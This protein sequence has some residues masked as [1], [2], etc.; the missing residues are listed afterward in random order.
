MPYS[1]DTSFTDTL[2]NCAPMR[3][4]LIATY[5]EMAKTLEHL[6]KGT[7]IK[8]I[9]VYAS[10]EDAVIA[11]K[12]LKDSVDIILTRGGT[13]YLIKQSISIPVISIPI[14]PFDLLRSVASLP[15]QYKRIAFSNFERGIFGTD[16]IE[17]TYKK[18]IYQ[19]HFTNRQDLKEIVYKAK[20]DGC[21]LFIGGAEGALYAQNIGLMTREIFSG[22]EAVYQALA[23]AIELVKVQRAERIVSKRLASAFNAL[24]EGICVTSE[25]GKITVFN[26]AAKRIMGFPVDETYIGKSIQDIHHKSIV[27]SIESCRKP[28]VNQ[29]LYICDKAVSANY[30]PIYEDQAFIG[31]VSTFQ[32]V[33]KIQILEGQIRRQLS[34]KGL[35]ARYTFDDILTQ[36]QNMFITKDLAK[37][38]AQTD[39]SVLITGESGTGK[40][41][42]AHSIHNTSKRAF[43]PF[44]TVNCA[45]IPEQ[46]LE[47]ELFGYSSGAFTGARK[48]GKAGLFEM[49]H[50]GTIFLDEIGEMPKSLQSRLLRVLQ[51]KEVMRVGDNKIISVNCR[52]IS[53]TNKNLKKLVLQGD[54]REDLYYRLSTFCIRVPPLRERTDDIPLLCHKFLENFSDM[55]NRLM[56]LL[57]NQLKKM[58]DYQWPGNVRELQSI[59][60]RVALLQEIQNS[61]DIEPY[62]GVTMQEN[63][64]LM[65]DGIT[66][67]LDSDLLLKDVGEEATLLYVNAIFKKNNNNHSRAAKQL[68]ISRTTLWRYLNIIPNNSEQK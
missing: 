38:Y 26:P 57:N 58:N 46:L 48:E 8:L 40:E 39:F 4:A 44:V 29:L 59:C 33:S 53:A 31:T 10:F 67:S 9:N 60:A 56:P 41:L 25:D 37:F 2:K 19:Y 34:Q 27:D 63:P 16:F 1:A 51:E 45:A 6:V 11:A 15:D 7:N 30:L 65:Q 5:P 61:K 64:F 54:F 3:I 50:N 20:A 28:N 14:S 62:I 21:D 52:V 12:K 24:A 55:P 35:I 47:S 23:E 49:A 43:G 32:D 18:S 36:N 68:G 22:E 42:F 13:G 17:K 66:L